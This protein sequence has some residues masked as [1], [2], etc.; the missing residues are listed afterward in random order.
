MIKDD[1]IK[2]AVKKISLNDEKR[3]KADLLKEVKNEI[4]ILMNL[5]HPYIVKYFDYHLA[6]ENIYIV[7]EYLA[8]TELLDYI[9]KDKYLAEDTASKLFYQVLLGINHTHYMNIIHR[10]IKAENI[11]FKDTNYKTVKII[12]YGLGIT[13]T[14]RCQGIVGTTFYMAPELFLADTY[15]KRVDVWSLGVLYYT[16]LS[17]FP[18]FNGETS[19]EVI[20]SVI[21]NTLHF[22]HPAF[23]AVSKES[24][25][26]IRVM[27]DKNAKNRIQLKDVIQH[28]LFFKA[29]T[30]LQTT[31]DKADVYVECLRNYKSLN[32][33][34]KAFRIKMTKLYEGYNDNIYQSLKEIYVSANKNKR[35]RMT[36][37][38]FIV[39]LY[40]MNIDENESLEI[41]ASLDISNDGEIE[42]SNFLSGFTSLE[43]INMRNAC[44]LMFSLIDTQDNNKM[45]KVQFKK[46]INSVKL[47]LEEQVLDELFELI[48]VKKVGYLGFDEFTKAFKKSFDLNVDESTAGDMG[49]PMTRMYVRI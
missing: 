25:E 12:D 8:G 29:Q 44:K 40:M 3:N 9:V 34:S 26:L 31:L 14:G 37:E 47:Y 15:D 38:E 18:P 23:N 17:G 32:H 10:D 6:S 43:H 35:G 39:L 7:T 19:K 36:K 5:D 46:F 4:E 1:N 16:M 21:K 28:P 49:M 42:Y 13:N 30:P 33:I 45:N 41:W 27:L 11:V 24:K 22:N 2:V 48:D 20:Q